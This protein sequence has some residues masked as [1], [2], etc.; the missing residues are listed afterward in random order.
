MIQNNNTDYI[1]SNAQ[2]VTRFQF[3]LTNL[4][5]NKIIELELMGLDTRY[6]TF[7][8]EILPRIYVLLK[9]A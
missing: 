2:Y 6:S 7:L 4:Y 3:Y 1:I 8:I 9:R 5:I